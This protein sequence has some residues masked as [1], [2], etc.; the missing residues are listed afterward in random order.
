[1]ILCRACA[2]WSESPS[3]CSACGE[4]DRLVQ[5]DEIGAL[6]IAHIDCDA[7]YASIEKRDDPSLE[8]KP[9]IVGGGKRGVVSTAC[10]VA[11]AYGVRSA[12][13]MFQ[14]LKLCPDAIVLH[15]G[16]A[17]YVE[18]GRIIRKMMQELTPLVEPLSIDEAFLDLS[19]TERLH[20]AAPAQSLARLQARIE[21]ERRLTVSVGLSFNKFLAKTAS[22]L[23]KPRGFSV[24]GRAEAL[25]FLSPRSVSTLPGVGPAGAAALEKQGYRRIGDLRAAGEAALTRALGDWG[26]KLY[27]L[28]IA[29]DDR[30][31]DPEG[32][33]KSIS[34]ETTFFAD[35][36][37]L[38]ALEDVLWPLCEKV[39][40]RARAA[41]IAGRTLTLKLRDKNF[42]TITRRMQFPDPTLLAHRIFEAARGLTAPEVDGRKA[43]RLIGVGLSDFAPAE[44]ADKGDLLDQRTPKIAAAESAVAKARARFGDGAVVTGRALKGKDE[45]DRRG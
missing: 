14:A 36:S 3:R 25:D 2:A 34:S 38:D 22:D 40:A 1:M 15:G 4:K 37:E 28:S 5:H 41:D 12:M 42:R 24:I 20:G 9:V 29:D 7:F 43:F 30:R 23:D 19:G 8:G 39:A 26:R 32:E 10:Y 6:A 17:K 33:R 27:R 31:V 18:E 13:P 16:M 21:E 44:E 11:R 45:D 35:I